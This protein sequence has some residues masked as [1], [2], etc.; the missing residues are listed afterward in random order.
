LLFFLF[1]VLF[2][3]YCIFKIVFSY[4]AIQP[5]VCFNKLSKW[6]FGGCTAVD[7]PV[8]LRKPVHCTIAID[9]CEECSRWSRTQQSGQ[10]NSCRQKISHLMCSSAYL[11]I[12]TQNIYWSTADRRLDNIGAECH[13]Q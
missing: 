5:Q 9:Y 12:S 8:S 10:E 4:S 11:Q 3:P 13:T 2:A 6:V 1:T 7:V